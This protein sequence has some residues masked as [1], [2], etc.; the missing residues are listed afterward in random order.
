MTRTGLLLPL[1]CVCAIASSA[2]SAERAGRSDGLI[3]CIGEKALD[4]VSSDWNKPGRIFHCL[5]TSDAKVDALRAKITAAGCY[6]KVSAAKFDGRC[7]PYVNNLVS[8]I[9]VTDESCVVPSE[10]IRRV[11]APYAIAVAPRGSACLPQPAKD[12]G[13]GL[14]AFTKPYPKEMDEWPQRLHGADNNCV[15]KDTVVGPPRHLQWVSSPAWLRAHIGAPSVTS[16]VSS[17]GR[18]FSIEDAETAENPL[19]PARWRLVARDAFNGIVLWTLVYPDWEQV[20][21]HMSSYHAQ[22]Q[23]RLAAIGETVYCTPG[24]AAPITALDAETGKVLRAYNGTQRTQEFVYYEGRLYAMVGDRMRYAGYRLAGP[25]GVD[26][27]KGKDANSSGQTGGTSR[28]SDAGPN[29][30]GEIVAFEGNGFPLSAYSPQT[31]SV[32]K[33]TSVIVAV[34][35]AS[36]K[37]IWRSGDILKYTGSSMAIKNGRLVYQCTQGLFCLDTETGKELW[38]SRKEIAYGT[39]DKPNVLVL[40]DDAVYCEEGGKVFAYSLA[41]G[42]DIWGK[43]LPARKAFA[44]PSDL[45]I[46]DGALWM[47]GTCNDASLVVTHPPTGFDLRTGEKIR[48]LDQKLSK[49]MGHDRCYR[50]FITERFFIDSKTGGPD[51][52]DFKTGTEYPCAFTRATCNTGPLPCNGL[53]Y[54]GP[55]SCQCHIPTGL[56]HFNAFYTD[57]EALRTKGQIV[58][59]ERSAR[60]EKGPAYG[61][62]AKAGDAS[63]PTFRQDQRRYGGTK[64]PVPAK[65]LKPLWKTPPGQTLTAPVIAD[66]KV[67]LAETETYTLVAMDAQSGGKLWQYVAGGRIDSPPTYYNGLVLFGSRDGWVYGLRSSDGA[68]VW[69]FRDLPDRLICAF[70]R[71]ESVW[72]VNG[73]VLVKDGTAYFCAGRSS[74]IDGGIFVYG[75][76]PASGE[77]RYQRRID[78]PNGEDNMPKFFDKGDVYEAAVPLG[79]TADV[80]S[81]EGG[82]IYLRHQAFKADLTDT[83]PG[84]HLMATAG[85]LEAQRNHREYKLVRENFEHRKMWTTLKTPHPT[86]DLIVSDG[87]DYYSVFGM[88]VNRGTSWN[89]RSG[90]T[91]VKKTLTDDQWVGTWQVTMPMTG[92]AMVLAADTVFV[93]GAPMIFPL[94]DLGGTYAGRRGAILRA[95]SAVDGATLAEYKLDKLPAWD[96]MAAAHGRLFI[97]NQDGS[98]ECWGN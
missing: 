98:V 89:P 84:K 43:A 21:A 67:F 13:N 59:V 17:G 2:V 44:G 54:C 58:K 94:D 24:L 29:T 30:E 91:L 69:R 62:E 37:E 10:E 41:D 87:T 86:G 34:D 81:A 8:R 16:M 61:A 27:R 5:E 64:E 60:L 55:W 33:P 90:Y 39:G 40:G 75:L 28:P 93:V 7:L 3:V 19:L 49:P 9:I 97:V 72:P 35:A 51:C 85:M 70:D 23:R 65:N 18:L 11:L 74:H 82:T 42:K 12:I 22:M 57:E 66:G 50:N 32:E 56:Q 68:L 52:M 47:V 6:G 96:G 38:A 14:E 1:L 95:V 77:L 83:A 88:P 63:W 71:L 4:G 15:A 53:I 45:L 73:S 80:M 26:S 25:L 46:A 76:D 36:G 31:P 48:T 20:T 92:K 79:N 78:G